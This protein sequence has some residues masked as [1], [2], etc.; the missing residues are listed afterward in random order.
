[1]VV[2]DVLEGTVHE[3][4]VAAVVAVLAGTVHQVLGAEVHQLPCQL[5]QLTLQGPCSTEGPARATSTLDRKE[6]LL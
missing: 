4:S 3:A 2:D 1:M 6:Q 5:G